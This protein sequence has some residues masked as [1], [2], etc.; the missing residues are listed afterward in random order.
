MLLTDDQDDKRMKETASTEAITEE[1]DRIVSK[2]E[3]HVPTST[4]KAF[5][6]QRKHVIKGCSF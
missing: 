2:W 5:E 6:N 3:P 1:M 4:M